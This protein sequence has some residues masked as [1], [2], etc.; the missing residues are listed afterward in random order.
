SESE[1]PGGRATSTTASKESVS[2]SARQGGE[3]SEGKSNV[4]GQGSFGTVVKVQ[5]R[6]T[7][8]IYALKT[9]KIKD[10]QEGRMASHVEREI[11]V[12][13]TMLHENLLRLHAYFQ[14]ESSINMVLEY[15]PRGE[16]YQIL[17]SANFFDEPRACRYFRHVSAGLQH[18]HAAGIMHRDLKPENL[19]VSH[20][21]VVK[22]CDFGWCAYFVRTDT[23]TVTGK[24][25]MA[26]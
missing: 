10:V 22:I 21:D 15:C 20:D 24:Q 9:M 17:K 25:S 5:H 2:S 11:E 14:D 23:D 12:Q 4:L 19:L 18:L 26:R 13:R 3:S 7:K 1:A 8:G 6:L 16:L